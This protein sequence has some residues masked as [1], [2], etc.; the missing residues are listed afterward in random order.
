MKKWVFFRKK[1]GFFQNKILADAA[2]H[3]ATVRELV[4]FGMVVGGVVD[5]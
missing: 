4:V 1:A 3:K 2:F 5:V